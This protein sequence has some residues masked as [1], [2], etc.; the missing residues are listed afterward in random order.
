MTIKNRGKKKKWIRNGL[1]SV[2]LLG[3]FY[4]IQANYLIHPVAGTS[5]EASLQDGDHVLLNKRSP[6]VRYSVIGFS[7]HGEDGM[8]VKRVIGMPG[9]AVLIEGNRLILSVGDSRFT[10]R[11]SFELDSN[12]AKELYGIK[13]IPSHSYFV[14]GDHVSVSKDSRSF[15]LVKKT[16]IEG[17][18]QYKISSFTEIK[19]VN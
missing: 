17:K 5:M 11:Y 1:I 2:L 16:E 19:P 10:T 8:F 4:W 18:V 13:A 3:L 12:A 15:G 9:D 14:M 6:I 7:A